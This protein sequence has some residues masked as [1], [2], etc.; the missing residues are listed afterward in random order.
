MKILSNGYIMGYIPQS[1]DSESDLRSNGPQQ[2]LKIE[3]PEDSEEEFLK[4]LRNN[5]VVYRAYCQGRSEGYNSGWEDCRR[6][7]IAAAQHLNH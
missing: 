7:G 4:R 6:A 3:T 1:N 2:A 5:P